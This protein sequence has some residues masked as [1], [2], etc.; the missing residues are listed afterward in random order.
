[1]LAGLLAL[2]GCVSPGERVAVDPAR[3]RYAIAALMPL[4]VS[5]REGWAEDIR[6]AFDALNIRP[7]AQNICAVL[8]VTEQES[9]FTADP[10][11]PGLPAMA[12]REIDRRAARFGIP[13]LLVN[14]ALSLPSPAGQ[15]YSERLANVKTER[16][17]SLIFEDFIGMVPLGKRLFGNLNPV[18]T[19]GPMQVSIKFAEQHAAEHKYPYADSPDVRREVFTRRG[20][21]YFGIAHLLD[22]PVSYDRMLFRFADFNAGHYASR[23]AAFQNA[24][25][26]VT[27]AKL[28][29]DGDL[30]IHGSSEPSQTELAIR[31]VADR[32]DLSETQIRRDLERGR[33]QAF[34]RTKL[35]RRMFELAD[36]ARD[37][38]VPRAIVP[39]I[40]LQS[41]KI[42]RELT[43]DWFA[44]RVDRR[45][46]KCLARGSAP[47][48]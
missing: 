18:R 20:G 13:K 2:N 8:A 43:T 48:S 45:Y 39:N 26:L 30:V 22:Y 14:A 36:E 1:M 12:R 15:S 9:T 37:S 34:E 21:M 11:V 5:D 31:E 17:L 29:F 24:V 42:T 46:R 10:V 19:G 27:K 44:Q 16:E 41:A 25:S 40:R 32:L 38:A 33:E 23:N 28:A 4:G 35:Y 47:T 3:A 6:T 7:T